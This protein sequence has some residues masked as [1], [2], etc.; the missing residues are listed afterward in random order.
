MPASRNEFQSIRLQLES[1]TFPG[2]MPTDLSRSFHQLPLAE[3]A[4]L[5]KKRLAGN[6][7]HSLLTKYYDTSFRLLS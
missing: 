5:E 4:S 1:E 2:F 3:Q 7:T 6:H